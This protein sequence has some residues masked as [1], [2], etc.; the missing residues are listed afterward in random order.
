MPWEPVNPLFVRMRFIRNL[1]YERQTNQVWLKITAMQRR[2]NTENQQSTF[3]QIQTKL[4]VGM[5]DHL[6]YKHLVDTFHSTSSLILV[7]MK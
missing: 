3:A 6:A 1:P 5:L 2:M 7:R 4:D